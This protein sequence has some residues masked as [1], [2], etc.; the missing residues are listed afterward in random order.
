MPELKHRDIVQQQQEQHQNQEVVDEGSSRD[1]KEVVKVKRGSGHGS[2]SQKD[3]RKHSQ[4]Q[5]M[6]KDGI[7]KV[8]SK[9]NTMKV[10]VCMSMMLPPRPPR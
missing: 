6:T 5:K 3:K 10:V 2:R 1:A 9:E 4:K 7:S 8:R